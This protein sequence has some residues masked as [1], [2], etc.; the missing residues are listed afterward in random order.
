[1]SNLIKI[2]PEEV[3]RVATEFA[4]QRAEAEQQISMLQNRINSLQWDGVTSEQFMLRFE[5]AKQMMVQYLERHQVVEDT[6]KKI[7]Q[8]FTDADQQGIRR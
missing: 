7:A 2:T 6:L 8:R 3:V 4:K 5:S 1:V